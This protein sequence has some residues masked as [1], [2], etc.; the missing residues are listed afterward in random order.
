M[1]IQRTSSK[2]EKTNAAGSFSE[3]L[4][5]FFKN[6]KH[7]SVAGPAAVRGHDGAVDKVGVVGCQKYCDG[8]DLGGRPVGW[9]DGHADACRFLSECADVAHR[10]GDIGGDSS[11]GDCVAADAFFRVHEGRV[12]GQPDDSM[13]GS[14]ISRTGTTS[15]KTAD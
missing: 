11:W 13:F 12:F 15:L 6:R 7:K 14:D 2:L 8:S 10:L 5:S 1:F 9:V 3:Q 4:H